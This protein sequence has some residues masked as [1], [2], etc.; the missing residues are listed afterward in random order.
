M[1]TNGK[2]RCIKQAIKPQQL[3]AIGDFH[4]QSIPWMTIKHSIPGEMC[5]IS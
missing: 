3:P 2:K 1:H 5:M 4:W